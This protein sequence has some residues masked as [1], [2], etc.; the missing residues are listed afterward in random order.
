MAHS[1]FPKRMLQPGPP[2]TGIWSVPCWPP[3]TAR[4]PAGRRGVCWGVGGCVGCHGTGCARWDSPRLEQRTHGCGGKRAERRSPAR[5]WL[6]PR[7]PEDMKAAAA[8]SPA[9][10]RHELPAE[11]H[12]ALSFLHRLINPDLQKKAAGWGPLNRL[13]R[14]LICLC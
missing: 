1:R 5:C 14:L 7:P 4:S 9:A 3:Q 13:S 10:A 2:G 12:W 6:A 11:L 8:W